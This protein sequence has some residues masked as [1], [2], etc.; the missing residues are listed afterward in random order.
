MTFFVNKPWL[1]AGCSFGSLNPVARIQLSLRVYKTK[2]N[3]QVFTLSGLSLSSF[4]F[5]PP[6][7]IHPPFWPHLCSPWISCSTVF[8]ITLSVFNGY[9]RS[10]ILPILCWTPNGFIKYIVEKR[11][12]LAVQWL[13]LHLPMQGVRVRPLV[14]ELRSHMPH[15]QKNP[16]NIKQKQYCNKFKKDF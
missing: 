13:R 8:R 7:Q 15:G 14:G 4:I 11:T 2:K 3:K 6:P 9:E 1:S 5:L 10:L 12:S 16:Q